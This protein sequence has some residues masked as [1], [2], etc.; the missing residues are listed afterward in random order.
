MK[1][2]EGW[3][4][5]LAYVAGLLATGLPWMYQDFPLAGVFL[6]LV[7]AIA[8]LTL[9]R[10]WW[11]SPQPRILFLAGF[12]ALF[13]TLYLSWR[14]PHP[15]PKDVSLLIPPEGEGQSL[16][17]VTLR[18]EVDSSPKLTR[19]DRVQ[20]WLQ[21][22]R[23]LEITGRTKAEQTTDTARGRVYVTVPLLQ[24]TGLYP[25]QIV[26]VTGVL[27]KPQAE[28]YK[29]GF[30]F[31]EYL[32]RQGGFSG[33]S[34]TQ[35]ADTGQRSQP[36]PLWKLRRRV[37]Q[38][39]TKALD[40][41]RGPLLSSMVL[42]RRSVDLPFATQ[43]LFRRVGLSHIIAVSGFHVSLVLGFVLQLMRRRSA[44][45]TFAAGTLTLLLL[46]LITGFQPSVLRAVLM[47]QAALVGLIVKRK[48]KP[49]GALIVAAGLLLLFNPLWIWDLG[50]QLS[51]LATLGLLISA[52]G[53]TRGLDWLPLPLAA[54]I[55]IPIAAT[56]WTLPLQLFHFGLV[57]PYSILVNILTTPFVTLSSG[58]G[59]LS[60]G[61]AIIWQPA[62]EFIAMLAGP[63][64]SS[65]ISIARFF[66]NLPGSSYALGKLTLPQVACLYGILLLFLWKAIWRRRGWI[67]AIA[68]AMLTIMPMQ[69][70]QA[71]RVQIT[72][73][74]AKPPILVIQDRNQT[75]LI[76]SGNP[77]TVRSTVM[78]FL[79]HQGINRLDWVV[80]TVST[81]DDRR[82]WL[83][84]LNSIPV[85]QFY[86]LNWTAT[87][88]PPQTA[89]IPPID[90]GTAPALTTPLTTSAS[91]TAPNPATASPTPAAEPSIPNSDVPESWMVQA[92]QAVL[93]GHDAT[94]AS[95][96]P[97]QSLN[98]GRG[99]I[100]IDP[101]SPNTWHYQRGEQRWLWMFN[102]DRS[103]QAAIAKSIALDPVSVL[104]WSGEELSRELI[105]KIQP[106]VA[107]AA[108]K[109]L[110]PDTLRL[111]LDN[112]IPAYWTGRDGAIQW[113][114]PNNVQPTREVLEVETSPL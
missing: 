59:F 56:L 77:A 112:E 81:N 6:F 14:M 26:D 100:T 61:F 31:S 15:G 19:S 49:I 41:P 46:L 57:S 70:A 86:E 65:L 113:T 72:A 90:P 23:L 110:Q 76:N 20:L 91:D 7:G 95:I 96:Q 48:A 51:F 25:G 85:N 13:A 40:S 84:L 102:L 60:A 82:G 44:K 30:D 58:L 88:A 79:Q 17:I 45:T 101:S 75:G 16:P 33:L 105:E 89:I 52:P 22:T 3:L 39:Q 67:V 73:L 98:A 34:A 42:G 5:L 27:Y 97:G 104:W 9:P 32:A 35:V 93:S 80:T 78:P 1:P 28:T 109:T 11:K 53:L 114:L 106:K 68:L 38:S 107:I 2:K 4:L 29:G 36:G 8:A 12:I 24:G 18:G 47:A 43:D 21:T 50:F 66:S 10:F 74:S 103:R 37:I 92:L 108:A 94:Y 62:G 87:L 71:A 99:V 55:A 54:A 64:V 83:R 63:V 69:Y 111:L